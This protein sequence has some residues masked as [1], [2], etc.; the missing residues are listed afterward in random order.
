MTATPSPSHPID[1][2]GD[3]L[4]RPAAQLLQALQQAAVPVPET[5]DLVRIPDT[6]D[7]AYWAYEQLR[8]AVEYQEQH[9]LMRSSIGRFLNRHFEEDVATSNTGYELVRELT[10]TRYL[11]NSSVQ[12]SLVDGLNRRLVAYQ[13]LN[14]RVGQHGRQGRYV[15]RIIDIA[16]ADL[17]NMLLPNP[18]QT[19][20]INFTFHSLYGNLETSQP[21]SEARAAALYAAVHRALLKSD[22]A[23]ISFYMFNNQFVQWH[24]DDRSIEAA[25]A[26]LPDFFKFLNSVLYG[27]DS[28]QM[29]KLARQNIAPYIIL[30]STLQ[31]LKDPV[32]LLTQPAKLLHKAEEVA[33]VQY[34]RVKKRL[35]SSVIR[36][37]I[38]LLITKMIVGLALEVP[39]DLYVYGELHPVPLLINLL[40]PPLYMLFL[41]LTI[42]TPDYRNT[43][44]IVRDLRA[45]LYGGK[46]HYRLPRGKHEKTSTGFNVL[47]GLVTLALLAGITWILY[48]IGYNAA[49][50]VIFFIFLSTVSFFGYRI[51]QSVR[52]LRVIEQGTTLDALASVIFTPFIRLGQW[53]SSRYSK[54]NIFII[55]LDF[56]IE[57]PLKTLLR[58][59]EQWLAFLREKQD[60]VL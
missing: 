52:E 25:A 15:S 23:T 40:F 42:K 20:L 6:A 30:H 7:N 41:G 28:Y 10:K 8:N 55:V 54:V 5:D 11:A 51:S 46:L 17:Q 14:A 47:Y 2:A 59:Y 45:T 32:P 19:A 18:Q 12:E 37:I 53:L 36:A 21:L 38:F 26:R 33:A 34:K 9:L 56:I 1:A 31:E 22:E 39:Y 35:R 24:R 4:T 58:L 57:A 50:A 3:S 27:D 16:S 48:R 44:R 49:S 60:D 29:N 43:D 13:Q